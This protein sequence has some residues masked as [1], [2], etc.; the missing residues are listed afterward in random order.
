MLG[1]HSF[2]QKGLTLLLAAFL[3]AFFAAVFYIN[4]SITPGF[5]CSDM[6]SDMLLAV[7]IWEQKTLFPSGWVYG[8]QL[9]VVATPVVAALFYGIAGNPFLAMGLASSLMG[10]L[11]AA[12]FLWMLRVVLNREASLFALVFLMALLAF[13]GDAYEKT[14]GWQLFFT[15]CTYY[16]CYGITVFLA[17]GCYIRSRQYWHTGHWTILA[18][19]CLLSLG[20][21][22]QSLRQT[23]VMC[24]PLLA[25][26]G[27][28][29][30][31]RIRTKEAI[32]QRP[33][34]VTM[35]ITMC[36][37]LG[38]II[39]KSLSVPQVEIFGQIAISH[40][41]DW[42]INLQESLVTIVTLFIRAE[43]FPLYVGGV[44]V[45]VYAVLA[46][47]LLVKAFLA[48]R[49]AEYELICLLIGSVLAIW[50]IDIVF[51]MNVRPLYYFML[52]PLIAALTA[53]LFMQ[54]R[55]QALI[56]LL[57]LGL[58]WA[59]WSIEIYP[60]CEKAYN[61]EQQGYYQVSDYLVEHGYET[62][63]TR[64]NRGEKLAIASDGIL[65]AGFWLTPFEGVTYICNPD[66]F[67]RD[68]ETAVYCFDGKAN[69]DAGV[70]CAEAYNAELELLRYFPE[71]DLYIYKSSVNLM[72]LGT[73]KRVSDN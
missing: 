69:A 23:A 42:L 20:T 52:L 10:G 11:F 13:F 37:V 6:Y 50:L 21:G 35:V 17:F 33:L 29:V 18:V 25:V 46:V 57:L 39:G 4:L 61:K 2:K 70:A 63:Y 44:I 32:L 38:L 58:S 71:L 5:Y 68:N 30:I 3:C 8:N 55:A 66:I 51:I 31:N 47:Y 64:W 16:A 41:A 43:E 49:S 1:E 60:A 36:N 67:Y 7:E 73:P 34:V 53:Q 59:A 28:Y 27:I 24:L 56:V 54:Q 22:M 40:P 19:T 9:Y 72:E 48:Q 45:T 12:S 62:I 14:N 15:M 65:K 26:E